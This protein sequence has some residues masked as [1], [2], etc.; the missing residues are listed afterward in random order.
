MTDTVVDDIDNGRPPP[1][2]PHHPMTREDS[3]A[4]TREKESSKYSHKQPQTSRISTSGA[5]DRATTMT[6]QH[7]QPLTMTTPTAQVNNEGNLMFKVR[8]TIRPKK[9]SQAA[10]EQVNVASL[11]R[12]FLKRFLEEAPGAQGRLDQL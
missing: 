12:T 5:G 4:Q 11:H 3:T 1:A 8:F 2:P 10:V 9:G 6:D 7:K